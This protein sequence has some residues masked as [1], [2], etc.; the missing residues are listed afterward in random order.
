[1]A[2]EIEYKKDNENITITIPITLLKFIAENA[3]DPYLI[4]DEQ[5]FAEKVL[6]AIQHDLGEL[7][8][9]MTGFQELIDEAI[10]EVYISGNECIELKT[11]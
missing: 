10:E 5:D 11:P 2:K 8:S 6:F 1:M 4:N 9:G 3:P 7:D